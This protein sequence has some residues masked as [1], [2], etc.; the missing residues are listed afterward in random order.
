MS[1]E[2]DTVRHTRC[3]YFKQPHI[4]RPVR[5]VKRS[6]ALPVL[7]PLTC[8]PRDITVLFQLGSYAHRDHAM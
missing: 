4:E 2:R 7:I 6:A 3:E 8:D 1:Q 5:S